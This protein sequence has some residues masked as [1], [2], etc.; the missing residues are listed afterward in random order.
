MEEHSLKVPRHLGIILDGN[1]R[2]AQKRG[3]ARTKGHVAGAENVVAITRACSDLGV[4][5]L[6]LYAFSTENWKRPIE[7]VSALMKLLVKF[8]TDYLDKMMAQNIRIMSMGDISKLPLMSRTTLNYAINKTKDNKG[9]VL[10]IGLSYGGRDEIVRAV[11]HLI[12]AGHKNVTEDLISASIDTAQLPELDLIIRTGGEERLS[13]FMIW[14]AAYA[15]FY[16]SDVLW[17]DFTPDELK[18]A[19]EAFACRDRRYGAIR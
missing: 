15:E 19:F 14:E 1:G 5:A 8:I 3:E 16:F 17:P 4:E 2:W 13:N 10:N 12:E 7:E 6:S 18:K 11:N 9:M